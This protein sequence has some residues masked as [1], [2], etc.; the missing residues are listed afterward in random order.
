LL[1]HSYVV[2]I[3]SVGHSTPTSFGVTGSREDAEGSVRE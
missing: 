1:V 3:L 2:L